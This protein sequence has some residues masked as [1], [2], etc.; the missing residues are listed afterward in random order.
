MGSRLLEETTVDCWRGWWERLYTH[1]QQDWG[2]G[3]GEDSSEVGG[4]GGGGRGRLVAPQHPILQY[5]ERKV[6]I[7]S[8]AKLIVRPFRGGY[9]KAA[10]SGSELW[11]PRHSTIHPPP[12]PGPPPPD[13][14]AVVPSHV[15]PLPSLPPPSHSQ[16]SYD[17][18][19]GRR[20]VDRRTKINIVGPHCA[21]AVRLTLAL[22]PWPGHGWKLVAWCGTYRERLWGLGAGGGG[23]SRD[24]SS[25]GG[26]GGG[27]EAEA[28]AAF[29]L[30][31]HKREGG[32]R[33]TGMQGRLTCLSVLSRCRQ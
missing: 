14:R 18:S 9:Q 28:R 26:N 32:Y 25:L 8:K 23:G 22:A 15:D 13:G 17:L 5:L 21:G 33:S 24:A 19:S 1:S 31:F 29:F 3:E 11:D 16:M 7:L 30:I 27:V 20:R 12:P 6:I 2:W 10:G 4:C